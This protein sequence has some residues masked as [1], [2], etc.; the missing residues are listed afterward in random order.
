M[1]KPRGPSAAVKPPR[2][3]LAWAGSKSIGRVSEIA[4]LSP[5]RKGCPPGE[6][7]TYEE[8][9]RQAI[10]SVAQRHMH[11]LPTE[12]SRVPT[13]HF[14]RMI[15]IRPEQY[16][17]GSEIPG[18]DY[19][20]TSGVGPTGGSGGD[21]VPLPMDDFGEMVSTQQPKTDL[22]LRSWVLTLVEFDGDLKVYMRDIAVKLGKDFDSIFMNCEHYPG[23][24]HFEPFWAWIRRYQITT[25]LFYATYSDLTVARLKQLE[26]FKAQFDAFV[27]RVR[28]PDGG[29]ADSMDELFDE[30][31][32]ENAQYAGGFPSSG[33]IF[34]TVQ[35]RG[36]R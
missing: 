17:V 20:A 27:R 29:R 5:I 22:G 16:L 19:Y 8:R 21:Q 32:R 12:L 28:T 2:G 3:P 7:R 1:E 24:A 18:V 35:N 36:D 25:Q 33:G 11:G 30:F 34:E 15:I 10:N 13:I 9:L 6:R 14:G 23:T 31:L 26:F 4:V